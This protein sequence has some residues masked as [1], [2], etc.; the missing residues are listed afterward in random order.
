M[1][2][3]APNLKQQVVWPPF[4]SVIM[5]A[6]RVYSATDVVTD[7]HVI[8]NFKL[9]SLYWTLGGSCVC[10]FVCW[11]FV[12][13]LGRKFS[14]I[15]W[16]SNYCMLYKH[17]NPDVIDCCFSEWL[18]GGTYDRG[19]LVRLPQNSTYISILQASSRGLGAQ[20]SSL[21]GNGGTFSGS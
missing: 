21:R 19:K 13:K 14:V 10:L 4:Q 7:N 2:M 20:S 18:L 5:K 17:K 1:A 16:L 9:Y 3:K 6:T 11:N 12:E 15:L 8:R